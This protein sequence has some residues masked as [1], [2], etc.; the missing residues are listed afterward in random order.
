MFTGF[1]P[2]QRRCSLGQQLPPVPPTGQELFQALGGQQPPRHGPSL[3]TSVPRGHLTEKAP[4][5][6]RSQK[7]NP[8][9]RA[10]AQ[11]PQGRIRLRVVARGHVGNDMSAVLWPS[12][13]VER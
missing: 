8:R 3:R 10:R 11:G 12:R 7:E 1:P 6:D 2:R 13:L 5:G 4:E 9:A